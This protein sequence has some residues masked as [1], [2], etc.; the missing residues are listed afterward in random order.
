MALPLD[1]RTSY[2]RRAARHKFGNTLKYP[3]AYRSKESLYLLPSPFR[4]SPQ[5]PLDKRWLERG[6]QTKGSLLTRRSPQVCRFLVCL[7]VH[8]L[9]HSPLILYESGPK[10]YRFL[11]GLLPVRH[12]SVRVRSALLL[13]ADS[14]V[15]SRVM[16]NT[17]R[18]SWKQYRRLNSS[19]GLLRSIEY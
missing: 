18:C 12:G 17:K 15:I 3:V 7:P 6:S 1:S 2:R 10:Q 16:L 5:R 13:I 19:G 11:K 4:A 9:A 8:Q 14:L